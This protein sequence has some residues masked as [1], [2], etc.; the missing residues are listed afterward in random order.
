MSL[1]DKN[2]VIPDQR[3]ITEHI[4]DACS[5]P[6][7]RGYL[8]L[9]AA[10]IIS[11]VPLSTP[12]VLVALLPALLAKRVP[13]VPLRLPVE[14]NIPD[15]N[16][17][18]PGGEGFNKARGAVYIG[19]D[20]DSGKEAWLSWNDQRLHDYVLGSTGSGKTETIL[21]IN[22]NYVLAGSGFLMGDGKGTMMFPK[23]TATLARMAGADDDHFV[24]SFLSGYKDVYGRSPI[25]KSNTINP[26]GEGNASTIK[27]LLTS[28]M[29]DGGGDNAIF[30]D[31]AASLADSL[32][33]AWVEG[34]DKGLFE[35][36]ITFISK[37]LALQQVF[38]L[39]QIEGLSDLPRQH[40]RSYLANT[41][42]DFNKPPAEQ[43]EN[44]TRMHGY[45][46]NY[47]M[48]VVTSFAISYR[49][50]YLCKQGE[51]NMRDVVQSHR[52]LTFTLPSLEKSGDEVSNLG[53]TLLVA[54]KSASSFGLGETMEGTREEAVDNLPANYPVPYKFN[55]DEFSFYVMENFSLLPA[56]F[57][58]INL[59]CLMGAQDYIGTTRAGEIDSGSIIANAR[60]KL[61]GAL[62]DSTTWEK[63]REL[64][65]E[66][67]MLSFSRYTNFGTLGNRF[68]PDMEA[69]HTRRCPLEI[70][71]LQEQVEGQ[72]H[73]LQRGKI[74]RLK[75]YYPNINENTVLDNYHL[76]RLIPSFKPKGEALQRLKTMRDFVSMLSQQNTLVLKPELIHEI[77]INEHINS[78]D[79]A[80]QGLKQYAQ[81]TRFNLTSQLSNTKNAVE[82]TD[83]A[84][85]TDLTDA[86]END[87]TEQN[88]AS[89]IAY[90]NDADAE[91]PILEND[92]KHQDAL[93]NVVDEWSMGLEETTEPTYTEPAVQNDT[94]EDLLYQTQL[95]AESY[96]SNDQTPAEEGVYALTESEC[97]AIEERYEFLGRLLGESEEN[98]KKEAKNIVNCIRKKVFYL[99]PPKPNAEPDMKERIK[100]L[101]EQ[102]DLFD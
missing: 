89:E 101:M 23:Q 72:F 98:A 76:Q 83:Q 36:D 61:F 77:V 11:L 46:V 99:L 60:T 41:G 86:S 30:A 96:F 3:T 27:E 97:Q 38:E 6:S 39:S 65:G 81:K 5:S 90:I 45:Y 78:D 42:Y 31:G 71:E 1:V 92:P 19:N 16:D 2:K 91:I 14:A 100:S 25:K 64:V 88:A 7:V 34:R 26:F 18:L 62:E 73:C 52:C 20:R 13:S 56:Q 58:G 80:I 32:S 44:C 69:Q 43:P 47:F 54:A 63:I 22:A 37:S 74:S 12:I 66:V 24:I 68:V 102:A 28:L 9:L 70:K 95:S 94:D 15:P 51:V 59:S 4:T 67:D 75:T 35:F 21:A 17:P 48:R 79:K 57:R 40:I 50:I 93:D 29:S 84:Q 53:K 55:F 82:T 33:P 49:H 8:Y 85:N 10:V 87:V